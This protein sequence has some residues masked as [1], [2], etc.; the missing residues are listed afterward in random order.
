MWV[1]PDYRGRKVGKAL[2]DAVINWAQ[3]EGY[4]QIILDVADEN[5]AAIRLYEASGF[6][7]NGVVCSLPPPREHVTEHQRALSLDSKL[8]R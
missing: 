8:A 5:T 7:P 3:N 6:L 1:A 2:I 4:T